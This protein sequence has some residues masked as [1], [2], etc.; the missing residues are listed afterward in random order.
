MLL[1]ASTADAY[2]WNGLKVVAESCPQLNQK[3]RIIE[4]LGPLNGQLPN[5]D[6]ETL[7]RYYKAA[8]GK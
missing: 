2:Y 1:L 7:T 3:D 4:A 6:E 5:V 8:R